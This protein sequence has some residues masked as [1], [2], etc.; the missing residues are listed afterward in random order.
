ME[1]ETLMSELSWLKRLA[2]ALV[3]DE[4]EADDLVQETWLVAS[5]HAPTDGR[6][7][8]PWLS[9]VALN[10]VRMRSRSS[11]RARAREAAVPEADATTL[12]DDLVD[13]LRAQRVVADEVLR[14][15]EP[16]R[17]T[18]LL[19]Y[20]EDLSSAE[21]ARRSGVPEGTV[22]RRLKVAL[23]ELRGRLHAEEKKTGQPVVAVLAPIAIQNGAA[24]VGS[25][26]LGAVLVKKLIAAIIVVV[27][28]FFAGRHFFKHHS[29]PSAP[30]IAATSGS[31]VMRTSQAAGEVRS[32][33]VVA[34]SDRAG[35]IANASVRC[36]PANG[37]IVVVTTGGD[38]T[39]S[40]DLAAGSWSIAA[41]AEGHL[42]N[43]QPLV[44]SHDE[45]I[46]IVLAVGGETLTGTVTD[47]TGGVI[48]GARIDAAALHANTKAGNAIAVAFTDK[49]GHYKLAVAGGE[50]L[51]GASHPEYASQTKYVDL[52]AGG[53]TASFALVPGGSIEGIVRDAQ[54]KEPVANATV[55]AHSDLAV[56][57]LA[58]VS[59]RVVKSDASGKFRFAGLRP[60]GYVVV[61]REGKR[62]SRSP[63]GVGV[64]V[65]EQQTNIEVAIAATATLRGRVVDETG[66][67]VAKVTVAAA[68]AGEADEAN[69]TT[70][71][72]AGTFV[73]EGLAPG[74]YALHGTGDR[75]V[76]EGKSIVELKK[77]D[78]DGIVVRVHRGASVRGHVQPPQICDVDIAKVEHDDAVPKSRAMTTGADGEFE[79][80]SFGAG[81]ATL[82]ARCPNGDQ[83]SLDVQVGASDVALPVTAGSAIAGRVVDRN[84]KPVAGVV[85]S[86]AANRST[87]IENGAVVSGFRGITS[88]TG[89]FA[90]ES[91]E[92]GTYRMSV[93]DVG[94]SMKLTKPIKVPL[95]AAQHATNIEITV[96]TPSGVI[97][98]TVTGPDGAPVADAWVALHQS[99]ADQLAAVSANDDDNGPHQMMITGDG[100][101]GREPPPTLT[102]SRGHFA[103]T[104][105]VPGRYQ[106]A[107]EAQAGKLRGGA[108]DVSTDAEVAIHLAG[109]SSLHGTVHG[110]RGP[111]E[112]FS[113]RVE[114]P[115]ERFPNASEPVFPP[116]T[117]PTVI[118]GAFTDGVFDIPR[119]DPGSY[120]IVVES[121]DGTGSTKITIAAEQAA[122]CDV[123]LIANGIVTGRLVDTAGQPVPGMG[124]LVMPEQ[125]GPGLRIE[126]HETPPTSGPDG[127]FTVQGSPGA[128]MLVVL[129]PT[130]TTKHGITVVDDKTIDVGDVVVD[131][132]N[133][134]HPPN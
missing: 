35:P 83:G 18:I 41:S 54:T 86:A 79:F 120:K 74:R 22:R 12:P 48:A 32:H 65:A 105:L 68:T 7:L 75:H 131:L 51:V 110:A 113:V 84:G 23:D 58:E 3:R 96:E 91:L 30:S 116:P 118:A 106:V 42:P 52:G 6:P 63:V 80:G 121:A 62:S 73:F 28:L 119:L 90:I 127:R 64:G 115:L 46:Q 44:V 104:G 100:T 72:A 38:G 15:G 117:E 98:G 56:L 10:L 89:T 57:E 31:N 94:R 45:R 109:V 93:L 21:I 25:T 14:L 20:F 29:A 132:Q 97:Q 61:A 87:R 129:G 67:P 124:V 37:E 111:T 112:L 17:N 36:A 59:E 1:V 9:R 103:L 60:G 49:T 24:S 2:S 134:P 27:G 5:K 40:V 69:K 95:A 102:D 107:A 47:M 123:T 26:A 81:T 33:V 11:K 4:T 55:R 43:A 13:R 88:A 122:T 71:D 16:Y 53:A 19:H 78:V 130:A 70:S 66:A 126:V 99:V 77:V 76:Q 125:D 101:G 82:T 85:V 128:R 133:P 50:I 8:K 34:V 39:A 108:T 92:A 114:G